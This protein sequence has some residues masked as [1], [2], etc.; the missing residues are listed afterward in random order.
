MVLSG[1]AI[2]AYSAPSDKPSE[3][4][5]AA[6]CAVGYWQ[7]MSFA[8]ISSPEQFGITLT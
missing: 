2:R 8:C 7:R 1:I 4:Y 5:V 3:H 6:T